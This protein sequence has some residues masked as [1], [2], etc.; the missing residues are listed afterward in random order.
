MI[1]FTGDTHYG[2]RLMISEK[3]RNRRPFSNTHE[4]NNALV[5]AWNAK[6]GHSDEV[7][8]LGDVSFMSPKW[9][10]EVLYRLN[11]RIYLLRGN[12]DKRMKGD[13]LD[14]FEWVQHYFELHVQKQLIVLCHYAFRVWNKSHHGSWNLHGHSHNNLSDVGGLQLD[15]G[16]DGREDY[17]PWSLDEVSDYMRARERV[18]VDHH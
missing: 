16:V 5:E 14:R 2:H 1:F 11:G 4:M 17:T 13:V 9:T 18:R 7:Y 10:K 15:V 12:H 8:H 6:V 3:V